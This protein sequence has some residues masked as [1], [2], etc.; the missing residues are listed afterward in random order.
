MADKK[1]K[2][3]I[4]L[5]VFLLI[6]LMA[7]IIFSGGDDASISGGENVTGTIFSPIQGWLY[8]TTTDIRNY[9]IDK[10][11]RKNLYREYKNLLDD[12]FAL[13]E[14]LIELNEVE[15]ENENLKAMLSFVSPKEEIIAAAANVTGR[16]PGVW[17]H[18]FTID[19]GKR[20]GIEDNMAVV[21]QY[22]L[23]G[24][25]IK[26][27]HNWAKVRTIVDDKSAISAII[28]RT[29]DQGT[30]QGMNDANTEEDESFVEMIFIPLDSDLREGDRV[31]TSG[32]G[33]IFP[34][35]ILIGEISEIRR[36][37]RNFYKTAVIYS[38]VDFK[39]LEQVMVLRK[40]DELYGE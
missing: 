35:G 39:R 15:K 34:K 27:G 14:K 40:P 26:T 23:V 2:G 7:M 38:K 8:S 3:W 28:E 30:I 36:D 16:N 17:F 25:V 13:A 5:P 29:R 22:G 4:W 31:L 12:N 33:D 21:N 24:K 37:E 11:I 10:K 32:H 9:Y 19:K 18:T 1:K 20:D 6:V